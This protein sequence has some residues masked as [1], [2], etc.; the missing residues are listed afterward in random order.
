[1]LSV[2]L[3]ALVKEVIDAGGGESLLNLRL[4]ATGLLALGITLV[5]LL[6][7]KIVPRICV[8]RHGPAFLLVDLF[9]ADRSIICETHIAI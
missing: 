9:S 2:E 3:S 5:L 8:D 7:F 1:M 6:Q 4:T